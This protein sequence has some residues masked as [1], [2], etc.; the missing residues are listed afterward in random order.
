MVRV[1]SR[2]RLGAG[3]LV[4]ASG[5]RGPKRGARRIHEG[6]ALDG[7]GGGG[8]LVALLLAGVRGARAGG[9]PRASE[10]RVGEFVCWL[11]LVVIVGGRGRAL[12]QCVGGSQLVWAQFGQLARSLADFLAGSLACSRRAH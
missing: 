1:S 4:R 2:R 3:A 9:A 10:R 7:L 8:Q 12:V 6:D 5:R 11:L